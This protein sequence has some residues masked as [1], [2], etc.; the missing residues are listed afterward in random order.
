MILPAF[1]FVEFFSDS[2]CPHY[3]SRPVLYYYEGLCNQTNC[4]I[5]LKYHIHWQTTVHAAF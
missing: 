5:A 4:T 3:I 2:Q 1:S